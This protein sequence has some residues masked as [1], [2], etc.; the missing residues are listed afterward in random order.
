MDNNTGVKTEEQQKLDKALQRV[1]TADKF[2]LFFLFTALLL[3][4]FLFY[5]NKF[6][7]EAAWFVNSRQTIYDILFYDVILMFVSTICKMVLTSSYNGLVKKQ[8]KS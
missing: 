8:R 6:M 3:V 7:E 2:R 4:L 1:K 5:G